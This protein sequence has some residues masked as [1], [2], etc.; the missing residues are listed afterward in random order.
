[1]DTIDRKQTIIEKLQLQKNDMEEK[2]KLF[3]DHLKKVGDEMD[4]LKKYKQDCSRKD[5][6]MKDYKGK[7]EKAKQEVE[8]LRGELS[9]LKK[10]KG[11]L[12]KQL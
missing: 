5:E 10:E 1:M 7:L 9:Q 6:I 12:E 11:R 4:F 2:V 3:E 8:E